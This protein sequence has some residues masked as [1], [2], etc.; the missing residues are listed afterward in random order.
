MDTPANG[1]V[2]VSARVPTCDLPTGDVPANENYLPSLSNP[3]T[4]FVCACTYYIFGAQRGL[5]FAFNKQCLR[6]CA[7]SRRQPYVYA[8]SS[9]QGQEFTVYRGSLRDCSTLVRQHAQ[10]STSCIDLAMHVTK[11]NAMKSSGNA[12]IFSTDP[13]AGKR[14]GL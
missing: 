14:K 6:L 10:Q 4:N 7:T 9:H 1:F 13:G 3:P 5:E 11:G 2:I 8:S 12:Y